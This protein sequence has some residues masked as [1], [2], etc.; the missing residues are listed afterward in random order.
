[1]SVS[2]SL[3]DT[4]TSEVINLANGNA[5]NLAQHLGFELETDHGYVGSIPAHE[6]AI[7]CRRALMCVVDGDVDPEIPTTIERNAGHATF[8]GCGRPAGYLRE[9]TKLLLE[10]CEMAHEGEMVDW[11]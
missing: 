8:I 10:M 9:K 11:Y 6:L 2:F 1:M 5:E 4:L 7:K 3:R